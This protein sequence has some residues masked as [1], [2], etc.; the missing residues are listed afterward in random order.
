MPTVELT[1]DLSLKLLQERL[2]DLESQIAQKERHLK[3]LHDQVGQ[4]EADLKKYQGQLGTTIE[5]NAVQSKKNK[6]LKDVFAAQH[7]ALQQQLAAQE[8]KA[9]QAINAADVRMRQAEAAEAKLLQTKAA[10]RTK[11]AAAVQALTQLDTVL[12]KAL[13][14]IIKELETLGA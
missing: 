1:A 8:S 9:A 7:A 10:V 3:G 13:D 6:E 5:E 11:V 4:V 2:K 14:P 12:S